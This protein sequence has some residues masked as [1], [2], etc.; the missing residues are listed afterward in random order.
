MGFQIVSR[1]FSRNEV[2][3][4]T[5][6]VLPKTLDFNSE[7]KQLFD[8]PIIFRDPFLGKYTIQKKEVSVKT[9]NQKALNPKN[10]N[11]PSIEYYGFVKGETSKSPLILLK[12]NNNLDRVRKGTQT[13]GLSIE[14]VF[15]DSVV[16]LFNNEKKIFFR[17]GR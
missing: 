4:V 11:W 5:T 8:L 15:K 3:T 6:P 12:I 10:I 1:L 13:S 17:K 16:V 14:Q 7:K 2:N 9:Y